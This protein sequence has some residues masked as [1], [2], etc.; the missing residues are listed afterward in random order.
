MEYAFLRVLPDA[1]DP[2]LLPIIYA[3]PGLVTLG[4]GIIVV[5]AVLIIKRFYKKKG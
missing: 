4:L 2:G 5:G 1:V 3:S